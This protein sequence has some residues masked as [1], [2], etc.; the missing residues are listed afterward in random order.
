MT[1]GVHSPPLK[2]T[3][4]TYIKT[5]KKLLLSLLAV[6]A[7]GMAACAQQKRGKTL[8]AYVSMTGTTAGAAKVLAGV[9]GADLYEIAPEMAY[10][11]ADLNWRNEKSR[12]YVEMHDLKFRPALREKKKDLSA[13]DTI[14]LGYPIWWN[15][16]P[17]LLNSFIEA[18]DLSGKTVIPFATSG[19]STISNS[20]KELKKAYPKVR[21]QEGKL[22]NGA[23]EKTVRQWLGK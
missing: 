2:Q 9:T 6:L 20:I 23:T 21:W 10:T 22:L 8:V 14:Y 18:N 12:C 16:A 11:D 3:R 5:M 15:I 17:T 1:A 7:I 4:K 19:G 13:Y